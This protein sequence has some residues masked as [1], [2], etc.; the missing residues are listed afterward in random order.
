MTA[1]FD[2]DDRPLSM[3]R[4]LWRDGIGIVAGVDEVGRG[5]LAGPVV[6]AAVIFDER[7]A[8]FAARIRDS[9][10]LTPE[11]RE[12]LFLLIEKHAVS[13]GVG[14]VDPSEIDEINILQ[15][16]LKAMK[17]AVARLDPRPELCLI[18]GNFRAPMKIPQRCI[19]KGDARVT[20]IGAAS[21]IAK[22]TR[23]RFM[24]GISE[25]YPA[26]GFAE[27][28]GYGTEIHLRALSEFGPTP[29]HRRTFAPVAQTA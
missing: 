17:I 2:L 26:Y 29:I 3:E 24:T 20:T 18:D 16:S 27:N 12:E 25:Q 10:Q 11:R 14:S 23:D 5:A 13:V 6:A 1:L 8:E 9:K 22:V 4:S 21:I 19:I 28:K 15:A 7:C